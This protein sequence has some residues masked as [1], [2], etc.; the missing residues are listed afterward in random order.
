[1]KNH[2]ENTSS[3]PIGIGK[4]LQ[5][6][7]ISYHDKHG[8]ERSWES[9]KRLKCNGAIVI[10]AVLKP[11]DKL[12]L[13]R[14]YRPPVDNYVIEFPAGLIEKDHSPE[15]TALRELK[16]ETGYNG[17]I[18]S[19]HPPCYSSPG[20]TAEHLYLAFVE[21]DENS[22]ENQ[23]IKPELEESEDIECMTIPLSE[24]DAFI[25]ESRQN[26]DL[27]DAK[28]ASFALGRNFSC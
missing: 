10:I 14:Q 25:A 17:K 5:L 4:W 9:V 20:M 15:E 21:V 11:S 28:L 16:E 6:D 26:K 3:A 13:I 7:Q 18:I 27:I 2:P 12:I 8:K 23:I 19:V 1:M 22:A 24:L